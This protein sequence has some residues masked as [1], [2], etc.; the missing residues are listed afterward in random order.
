[1][2]ILD[3]FFATEKTYT[4]TVQTR[5]ETFANGEMSTPTWTTSKT[6]R[7]LVW[8]GGVNDSV[9]SERLRPEIEAVAL[10]KPS[11]VAVSDFPDTA[12][13]SISGLGDWSIVKAVDI[14]EQGGVIQVYM[15][16]IK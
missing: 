13:L 11:D 2:N 1:M 3:S 8:R 10:F 15:K 9:I 16:E 4:A 5:T 7:C 12:R 14:A 6:A